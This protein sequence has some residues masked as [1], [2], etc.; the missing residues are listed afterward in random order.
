MQ[1]SEVLEVVPKFYYCLLNIFCLFGQ[2]RATPQ[3]VTLINL[4]GLC[5]IQVK[6]PA[7]FPHKALDRVFCS[8]K[9]IPACSVIA[10]FDYFS[11]SPFDQNLY[12]DSEKLKITACSNRRF[13]KMLPFRHI[14]VSE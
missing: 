8:L 5:K 11:L 12:I 2:G 3:Q 10:Q 7:R 6:D 13:C 14:D 9:K 4:L 1:S